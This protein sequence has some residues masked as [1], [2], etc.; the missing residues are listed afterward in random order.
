VTEG[1]EATLAESEAGLNKQRGRPARFSIALVVAP[2]FSSTALSRYTAPGKAYGL[3]LGLAV[4]HRFSVQ[5]GMLR[6]SKKYNGYG[7]EYQ[8]PE[9]Y[10]ARR[11]NGVIPDHVK[12]A[13]EILEIP[14]IM[15]YNVKQNERSRFYVAAGVSS[16]LMMSES[17]AYSFETP[18][19]G[20]AEGWSSTEPSSYLFGIG[21]LSV[22]YE[23]Q[24]NPRLGIGIE[25]FL[26]VPFDGIGW[27]DI[28]LF[29]T[30]AYI[31]LR[32]RFLKRDPVV[33]IDER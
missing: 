16:Y 12:G 9:G 18:N 27:S 10:W 25:P 19:P 24:I 22:G 32:Y 31:S 26:K 3:L 2:D 15:Q 1:D 14:V 7:G 6:S 33:S 29:T 28:D 20:A 8:P 21:H 13:C 5:T 11:T 4:S 23:R 17:Y 30:G